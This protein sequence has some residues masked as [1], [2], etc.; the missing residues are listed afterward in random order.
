MNDS[1]LA[2]QLRQRAARLIEASDLIDG[3]KTLIV[4]GASLDK[5]PGDGTCCHDT[6]GPNL[7]FGTTSVVVD[8]SCG[9]DRFGAN[10]ASTGCP[11]SHVAG[12]SQTG[13]ENV[14]GWQGL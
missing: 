10:C 4:D 12:I 5:C 9:P 2:D 6:C 3:Q 14:D 1:D 13:A 8:C 11:R 7:G